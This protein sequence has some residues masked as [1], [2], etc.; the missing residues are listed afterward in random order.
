MKI[1]SLPGLLYLA[2]TLACTGCSTTSIFQWNMD[3]FR[4]S[5]AKNPVTEIVSIWQPG[6]GT[7]GQGKNCRGFVGQ[8]HFFTAKEAAPVVADGTIRVYLFDDQGTPEEQVKPIHQ[9]DFSPEAWQTHM[10]KG[11]LGPTYT[12]FIPYP[13]KGSH[14]ARCSLRVRYIPKHGG[15][16]YFSE[17]VNLVLPGTKIKSIAKK[18]ESQTATEVPQLAKLLPEN[19]PAARSRSGD[20][21]ESIQEMLSRMN[22][23][24]DAR[25][26][27]SA[28]PL[29]PAEKDRILREAREKLMGATPTKPAAPVS[30]VEEI[31]IPSRSSKRLP[32]NDAPA[33]GTPAKNDDSATDDDKLP[34]LA[35]EADSAG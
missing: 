24:P 18:S 3:G 5:S 26:Q 2:A 15:A 31:R 25:K 10:A 4:Y 16:P 28:V 32:E 27:V 1:R 35:S 7:D 23:T 8:I 22:R 20:S 12:A 21:T 29:T 11:K 17:M 9:Y 30:E 14:E 13:R 19:K 33:K 34:D 6:E